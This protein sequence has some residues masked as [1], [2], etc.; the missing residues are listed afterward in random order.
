MNESFFHHSRLKFAHSC[1][2]NGKWWM[3][4][5]PHLSMKHL[6]CQCRNDHQFKCQLCKQECCWWKVLSGIPVVNNDSTHS[7]VILLWWSI[8]YTK[9][10]LHICP[11]RERDPSPVALPGVSCFF[12]LPVKG[13]FGGFLLI[14][15]EGIERAMLYRLQFWLWHDLRLH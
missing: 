12:F 4:S 3:W 13:F 9:H 1:F 14:W 8:L 7:T 10:Q 6:V 15:N 2:V 5:L 11:S